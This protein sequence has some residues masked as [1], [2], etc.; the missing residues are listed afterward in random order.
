MI[1]VTVHVLPVPAVLQAVQWAHL[2]TYQWSMFTSGLHFITTIL[3]DEQ[4]ASLIACDKVSQSSAVLI[5]R[6]T[7]SLRHFASECQWEE[8]ELSWLHNRA[9]T[10]HLPLPPSVINDDWC[11]SAF[12]AVTLHRRQQQLATIR[13]HIATALTLQLLSL[14]CS[15]LT[16]FYFVFLWTLTLWDNEKWSLWWWCCLALISNYQV[17]F[18]C[19][20]CCFPIH[21]PSVFTLPKY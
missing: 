14:D 18:C 15:I 13:P 11:W 9:I 3:A 19:Y 17:T 12:T 8:G 7:V 4:K 16:R 2:I 5:C 21:L 10:Y 6:Q 1:S 20:S